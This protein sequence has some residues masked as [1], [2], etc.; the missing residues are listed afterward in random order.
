[1]GNR[2]VFAYARCLHRDDG[3]SPEWRPCIARPDGAGKRSYKVSWAFTPN[4]SSEQDGSQEQSYD[5]GSVLLAPREPE[6]IDASVPEHQSL[7]AGA[8][9][10]RAIGKSDH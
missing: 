4:L 1:M 2:Q 3:S 10:L 9:D 7:L 5:E 8:Q 6:I